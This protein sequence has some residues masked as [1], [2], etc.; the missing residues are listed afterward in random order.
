M[1]S[2]IYRGDYQPN[3]A[4]AP[5]DDVRVRQ[6]FDLALN[7]Q[8]LST[9][10]NQGSTLATNH[11]VPEGMYGYDPDLTAPDGTMTLTG[12]T[13]KATALMKKYAADKCGG[14]LSTCL[15]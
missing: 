3:W 9:Q 8:V 14:Q 13:A 2:R 4:K 11:I 6:A 10:V 1:R 15:R 12:D 7:K 5:F